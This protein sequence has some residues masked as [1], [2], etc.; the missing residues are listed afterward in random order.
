MNQN[1]M[2]P[3]SQAK[4]SCLISYFHAFSIFTLNA[5]V[6]ASVMT[7]LAL[8]LFF[9]NDPCFNFKEKFQTHIIIS[10]VR[11]NLLMIPKK[12]LLSLA[13]FDIYLFHQNVFN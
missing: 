9:L 1:Y 7:I 12:L 5:L 4:W 10:V 6:K 2:T 13:H 11:A 3:I 8:Y